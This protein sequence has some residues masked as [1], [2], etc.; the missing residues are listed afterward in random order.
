MDF[1]ARMLSLAAI[2]FFAFTTEAAI[3]FGSTV[4]ALALGVHLYPIHQLLSTIVPLN[5]VMQSYMVTRHRDHI[6]FDL[7]L[8]RIL[9]WMG[10]GVAAGLAVFQ[11]ASSDT[12]KRIFGIFVLAVAVREAVKVARPRDGSTI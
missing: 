2:V 8:R 10:V 3:G 12:L 4:I 7:M 5:L 1:D 6:A 9:P 11:Y